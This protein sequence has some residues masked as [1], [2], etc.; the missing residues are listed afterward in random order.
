MRYDCAMTT[1]TAPF[2]LLEIQTQ[3]R[4]QLALAFGF[5]NASADPGVWRVIAAWRGRGCTGP[6][7]EMVAELSWPNDKAQALA[8]SMIGLSG[9]EL[10][11]LV[12]PSACFRALALHA[13]SRASEIGGSGFAE[14][15][16][17]GPLLRSAT[18]SATSRCICFERDELAGMAT[19]FVLLAQATGGDVRFSHPELEDEARSSAALAEA[20]SPFELRLGEAT[21]TREAIEPDKD[22]AWL[23]Q[24]GGRGPMRLD[25]RDAARGLGLPPDI[26]MLASPLAREP[27]LDAQAIVAKIEEALSA[28]SPAPFHRTP[29]TA[30]ERRDPLFGLGDFQAL[31]DAF[32]L[33]LATKEPAAARTSAP[34]L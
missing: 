27:I 32:F 25:L 20:E 15:P 1:P 6:K 18:D 26:S 30:E 12:L 4:R 8:C 21:F 17:S 5:W 9:A 10:P 28:G 22:L 3:N 14:A 19:G 33:R 34:S 29:N 11:E 13:M 2:D 31:Q 23:D 24:Q 16:S 7:D